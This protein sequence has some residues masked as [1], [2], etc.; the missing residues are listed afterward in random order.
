MLKRIRK[1][2]NDRAR[3]SSVQYRERVAAIK[4]F[5]E[6]ADLLEHI[7]VSG[8]Y[9]GFYM[10][11]HVKELGRYGVAPGEISWDLMNSTVE[12]INE[13]IRPHGTLCGHVRVLS[14]YDKY[15]TETLNFLGEDLKGM[16]N[17]PWTQWPK[18]LQD[19]FFERRILLSNW[20]WCMIAHLRA[21]AKLLERLL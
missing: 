4:R 11:N 2:L 1:Y 6:A 3:K 15:V 14:R 13:C 8:R 19:K 12:L 21:D 20:Y 10:C 16:T 9:N 18:E 17:K 5:R 7:L